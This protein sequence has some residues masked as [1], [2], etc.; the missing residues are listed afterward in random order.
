MNSNT[1][2]LNTDR[3]Y[4]PTTD[5]PLAEGQGYLA[6]ILDQAFQILDGINVVSILSELSIDKSYRELYAKT[7]IGE[8]VFLDYGRRLLS[9]VLELAL[10]RAQELPD[11]EQYELE[12][13]TVQ[14][15]ELAFEMIEDAGFSSLEPG[16]DASHIQQLAIDLAIELDEELEQQA[17]E[18]DSYLE[19]VRWEGKER[20][21]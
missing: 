10:E 17:F 1:Q 7:E 21:A 3:P 4:D 8:Q 18:F 13:L 19:G 14:Q 2:K 12:E 15:M 20:F 9:D 6:R 5:A 11:I 16:S